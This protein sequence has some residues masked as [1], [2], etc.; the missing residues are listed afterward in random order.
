M[1]PREL[2]AEDTSCGSRSGTIGICFNEAA[3]VTR[4][5]PSVPPTRL[6]RARSRFNEAAGVTRGR[7]PHSGQ[8]KQVPVGFNEAAGVTRGRPTPGDLEEP[9][10]LHA[11]MRP[12]ELPAEDDSSTSA[13]QGRMPSFNEA[14]GV[15]RG[16]PDGREAW[17][18]WRTGFNEA[19]GVTR[20]RLLPFG[21]V[22]P[23]GFASMRP[24]ELPAEDATPLIAREPD[25]LPA[26]MRPRELPAEDE[27]TDRLWDGERWWASMRP[28]E[29]P[30][31]DAGRRCRGRAFRLS[32]NRYG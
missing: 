11:S 4:G 9:Q 24:R 28:R 20:G 2:P 19:A 10:Q 29:L 12:R 3:G 25:F 30:A 22:D 32:S 7:R 8:V 6:P 18:A 1:R 27:S 21:M 31:E 23:A 14:A 15:T 17:S 26:S 16:R 5:R 13:G